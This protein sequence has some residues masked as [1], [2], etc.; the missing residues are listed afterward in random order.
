MADTGSIFIQISD[1]N[2]HHL[3]E[4]LDEVFG[5]ENFVSEIILKKTSGLGTACQ[6]SS[7]PRADAVFQPIVNSTST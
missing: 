1:E 6:A 7:P 4:I 3:R 5:V 2:V